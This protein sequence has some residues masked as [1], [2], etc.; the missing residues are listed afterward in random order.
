MIKALFGV[1][2]IVLANGIST[3]MAIALSNTARDPEVAV[4]EEFELALDKGTI[5]AI[6]L[7]IIRHPDSDLAAAARNRRRELAKPPDPLRIAK[8]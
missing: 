4:R 2:A 5:E 3:M 7:F 6:D 8:P 1:T